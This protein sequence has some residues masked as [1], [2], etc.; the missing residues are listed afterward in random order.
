ML[1]DRLKQ[2][3]AHKKISYRD[4]ERIT[5]LSNGT[6]AR[7]RET[8]RHSTFN[9]IANLCDINVDWLLTGEGSMLK[10]N[11]HIENGGVVNS[12]RSRN[13]NL[14]VVPLI[15]AS[16]FA[17]NVNGFAPEGQSLDKC[18]L[19]ASPIR[20]AEL[21]IPIT[22]DSMTPD[23]PDGA[24]AYIK[25]INEAAFIPWGH[26]VILDTENGAFIKLIFPDD[27]DDSFIWAKSIN[28]KYPPI[29]IPKASIYRIFRVLGTSRI[30]TTM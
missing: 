20:G 24:I 15:P 2:Y 8:T 4:F 23:Y 17:G 25:R 22:G 12:N 21:A 30:F 6:A 19:I 26:A 14:S 5:N 10:D 27:E 16:A 11:S 18:E 7:L 9:R 1:Q 29:H 13:E 3:L 28:T